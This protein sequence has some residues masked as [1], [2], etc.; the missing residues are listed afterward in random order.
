[1]PLNPESTG[2]AVQWNVDLARLEWTL[3]R[4]TPA[5]LHCCMSSNTDSLLNAA[6]AVS[7][8]AGEAAL[9]GVSSHFLAANGH[10]QDGGELLQAALNLAHSVKVLASNLPCRVVNDGKV[11][12]ADAVPALCIQRLEAAAGAG[13]GGGARRKTPKAKAASVSKVE[14]AARAGASAAKKRKKE[15]EEG[16]EESDRLTPKSGTGRGEGHTPARDAQ[17]H[18]KQAK[19]PA[20]AKGRAIKTPRSSKRGTAQ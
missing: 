18:A 13:V 10:A 20:S 12:E 14:G 15:E 2:L 5:C 9:D 7:D 11:L 4:T 8:A 3:A 19:T 16:G 17:N 6:L 1:M